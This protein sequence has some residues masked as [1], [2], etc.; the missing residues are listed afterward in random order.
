MSAAKIQAEARDLVAR[1]PNQPPI[2]VVAVDAYGHRRLYPVTA[3]ADAI[4]AL[5]GAKTLEQWHIDL[6]DRELALR[7]RVQSLDGLRA[8]IQAYEEWIKAEDAIRGAR[9]MMATATAEA[10]A[11]PS[12]V[13][14]SARAANREA[15]RA[16]CEAAERGEIPPPPP[17]AEIPDVGG[18]AMDGQAWK[19]DGR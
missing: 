16:Y 19:E 3:T 2:V 4:A 6:A 11:L 18:D 14:L 1:L 5:V 9:A 7:Y 17:P 15:R 10:L 13:Q 12:P 8:E